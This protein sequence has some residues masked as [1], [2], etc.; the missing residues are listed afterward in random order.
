MD[1]DILKELDFESSFSEDLEDTLYLIGVHLS[2]I[3]DIIKNVEAQDTFKTM[4]WLSA[5]A[6]LDSGKLKTLGFLFISSLYT[7][8]IDFHETGEFVELIADSEEFM[9]LDIPTDSFWETAQTEVFQSKHS[10]ETQLRPLIEVFW[11]STDEVS[12]LLLISQM[13]ALFHKMLYHAG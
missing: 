13:A 10:A 6:G 12:Q 9:N 5:I 4:I 11:E 1:D 2:V 8:G 7:I 3:E